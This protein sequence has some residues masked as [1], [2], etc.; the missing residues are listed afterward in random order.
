MAELLGKPAAAMFPSGIMA[1]QSVLRVW[2]DRQGSSRIAIPALSHLLHYELD[3]PQLFNGFDYERLTIGAKVPTVA[4]LEAIPGRLGAVLLELPL[5]DAG[6]LLPTWDE[7][8]RFRWR[9]A[10]RRTAAL[11]RSAALGVAALPRT[12]LAEIA[13][14]ADTVYVSFYKGLGGLAGA[15]VAGPSDVVAEAR[16]WRSRHGGTL[17]T[18]A[19]FALSGLRGL[20]L[21]LPRMAEYHQRAVEAR[22]RFQERGFRIVPSPPHTNAF[23]L[24]IDR[25][26]EEV[27]ER[28]LAHLER[29]HTA[30]VSPLTRAR[31]RPRH[32]RS[33]PWERPR[34][35]G[36]SRR[37]PRRWRGCSLTEPAVRGSTL[38]SVAR[39][40][41]V[42]SAGDHRPQVVR[43]MEPP[44]VTVDPLFDVLD[45]LVSNQVLTPEQ[46]NEVYQAVVQSNV[47]T[48]AATTPATAPAAA[49][50]AGAATTSAITAPATAATPT[51]ANA[52]ARRARWSRAR[53]GAGFGTVGLGLLAA[54]FLTSYLLALSDLGWNTVIG[55]VGPILVLALVL[56]LSEFRP[57]GERA[58]DA[59]GVRG[60]AGA[61]RA[62]ADGAHH[63]GIRAALLRER[64]GHAVR[65][66]GRL[67]GLATAD[68]R[69]PGRRRGSARHR[70]T[71]QRPAQRATRSPTATSSRSELW[72]PAMAWS[73]S[74]WVGGTAAGRWPESSVAAS[75]WSA[76]PWSSRSTGSAGSSR[77]GR[78][79]RHGSTIGATS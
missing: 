13:D 61:Y 41:G 32:G 67:R 70:Q 71:A 30:L 52:V 7:P 79:G 5:R 56:V 34:W 36:A 21:L 57:T 60:V 6:Y 4:D 12:L 44:D 66:P 39:R 64:A 10:T 25:P 58:P 55:M 15:V 31:C 27:N 23:Q 69:R 78:S 28:V 75:R 40:C 8:T 48:V 50:A 47:L 14:L 63:R 65:R 72:W 43:T 1:Q 11:R 37:R 26:A 59:G 49:P 19:P 42:T 51:P 54:A 74:P 38:G 46:A 68:L 18:L 2:A 53:F 20:R 22:G 33:S 9:R 29:D 62:G 45:P 3:G 16:R 76:C 35:S 73:W 24:Y 77:S 17:F